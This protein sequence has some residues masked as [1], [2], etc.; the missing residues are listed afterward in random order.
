MKY[1]NSIKTKH[2]KVLHIPHTK[3]DMADYLKPIDITNN[4]ARFLFNL[5][6]RMVDVRTNFEGRYSDRLCPLCAED[7]DHQPH[8]LVC[9]VLD[10]AGSIV[11]NIP[12]YKNIFEGTLEEKISTSRIIEAKYA[13]RKKIL[14]QSEN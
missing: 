6:C 11:Q 1:L 8:L 10:Q 14:K 3:L 9:E 4:E 13:L 12:V 2:S 7:D 5:R